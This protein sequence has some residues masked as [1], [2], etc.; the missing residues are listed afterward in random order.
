M[1]KGTHNPKAVESANDYSMTLLSLHIS[2]AYA[3]MYMENTCKNGETNT[4]TRKNVHLRS[5]IAQ[6]RQIVPCCKHWTLLATY[7]AY[8][9]MHNNRCLL[10]DLI[11]II[12]SIFTHLKHLKNAVVFKLRK[13]IRLIPATK[14][15]I[16]KS[17]SPVDITYI[18]THKI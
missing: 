3:C 8:S 5:K 16:Y 2:T 11:H 12:L 9:R 4:R 17:F 6:L 7:K 10:Y 18:R 1:Q 15:L 14:N 13:N